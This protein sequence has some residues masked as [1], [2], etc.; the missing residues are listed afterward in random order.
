MLAGEAMS[1]GPLRVSM[2]YAGYGKPLEMPE[3][4]LRP[5]V[6]EKSSP[7]YLIQGG[8]PLHGEVRLSGAKNAVTKMVIASLL[9]AEPCILRNVPLIGDLHLT[10]ALCR[11][12]GPVSNW[13]TTPSIST[14]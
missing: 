12:L 1:R 7:F 9:T 14:P 10:I 3:E 5:M 8:T 13:T 4:S 6:M 11:A 2:L